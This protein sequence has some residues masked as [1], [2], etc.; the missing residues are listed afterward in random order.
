MAARTL[1]GRAASFMAKHAVHRRRVARREH[2]QVLTFALLLAAAL[3]AGC[4]LH[5]LYGFLSIRGDAQVANAAQYMLQDDITFLV[6]PSDAGEI[7]VQNPVD[8]EALQQQ[9]EDA[10]AWIQI[11]GTSISLP[12]VQSADEEDFYL[13]HD[14]DGNDDFMGTLYTQPLNAKDFSDPV[15]VIYGH[16]FPKH[17]TMF[18]DLHEL[19]DPAVFDA[20]DEFRIYT[21]HVVYTYAVIAAYET[22]NQH[23]L[24]SMGSV[25]DYFGSVL[26]H[27]EE[28]AQVREGSALDARK[29]K[30]VQLS[31]CTIPSDPEKRFIVTGALLSQQPC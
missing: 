2:S 16:T 9:N 24:R 17:G 28:S 10:Y 21:P 23:I 7:L 11:P 31:T 26:D 25:E 6:A 30:I 18:T 15:T 4:S 29:D 13:D 20:L 14:L 5:G 1:N 12:V 22:D 3:L 19:E 27:E 8:F